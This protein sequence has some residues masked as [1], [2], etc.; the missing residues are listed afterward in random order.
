MNSIFNKSLLR[1]LKIK[2]RNILTKIKENTRHL[3]L[4]LLNSVYDKKFR[5]LV[6][7]IFGVVLR[8]NGEFFGDLL[9][10][11]DYWL[12]DLGG[13]VNNGSFEFNEI[14]YMK[15]RSISLALKELRVKRNTINQGTHKQGI[16]DLVDKLV[17]FWRFFTEKLFDSFKE[18]K[19]VDL[20]LVKFSK[21]IDKC[22]LYTFLIGNNNV[23][24]DSRVIGGV[25][26]LMIKTEK[27]LQI[28]KGNNSE[29]TVYEQ[30]EKTCIVLTHQFAELL[31]VSPLIFKEFIANFYEYSLGIFQVKWNRENLQKGTSLFL[32]KVFKTF[33]FYTKPQDITSK[34]LHVRLKIDPESQRVC[35][36]AFFN[37]FNNE[38]TIRDIFSHVVGNLMIYEENIDPERFIE[39][40]ESIGIDTVISE[41]DCSLP[42]IGSLIVEQ[43]FYRFPEISLLVYYDSLNEV[44]ENKIQVPTEIQD[45]VFN[46][47]SYLPKVYS[48]LNISCESFDI[49]K[50]MQYLAEKGKSEIVFAR[51]FLIIL[52]NFIFVANFG[53]K[54]TIANSV[55]EYLNLNDEVVRFEALDCLSLLVKNDNN[56]ELD[57]PLLIG[58]TTP[59][60]I[61]M[62]KNFQTPKLLVKLNTYLLTVFEK[63]Q[64]NL[65]PNVINALKSLNITDIVNKEPKLMKPMMN[66]II[67]H[68]IVNFLDKDNAFVFD[69][70]LQF[71]NLCLDSFDNEEADVI[72]K[73][74]GLTLRKLNGDSQNNPQIKQIKD[75]FLLYFNK[76]Y[77]LQQSEVHDLLLILMEELILSGLNISDFDCFGVLMKFSEDCQN[78][79]SEESDLLKSSIFSVYTTLLL[80]AKESNS[81]SFANFQVGLLA[82][83]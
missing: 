8:G 71:I 51:R 23:N 45:N 43:L 47:I 76:F 21:T 66:E 49:M 53:D 83:F 63:S 70:A 55:I 7:G 64:F 3:V 52:K 30:V 12:N 38:K 42:K 20:T 26:D 18:N 44:I 39:D 65:T 36:D 16:L 32:L 10:V 59:I 80:I 17:Y 31:T 57:Y 27:L 19:E 69:F 74:I 78:F 73:F 79:T 56:N 1:F 41:L 46:V 28:I 6:D 58:L 67:S 68:L 81:F 54:K 22:L 2:D 61:N 75:W 4:N 37:F 62:L 15:F 35:Y 14:S 82:L 25:R 9:M 24:H 33:L 34:N 77:S 11:A 60:S 40:Q 48:S 72:L 29:D 50:V 13:K 5:K